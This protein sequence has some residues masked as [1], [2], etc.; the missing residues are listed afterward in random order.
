MQKTPG[1]TLL[2]LLITIGLIGLGIAAI[3]FFINIITPILLTIEDRPSVLPDL[4]Q[5]TIIVQGPGTI[6]IGDQIISGGT[7]SDIISIPS[8][9]SENLPISYN[10]GCPIAISRNGL[11]N[12]PITLSS[13]SDLISFTTALFEEHDIT[14]TELTIAPYDTINFLVGSYCW[15][16]IIMYNKSTGDITHGMIVPAPYGEDTEFRIPLPNGFAIDDSS[17]QVIYLTPQTYTGNP[18]ENFGGTTTE[19]VPSGGENLYCSVT[20]PNITEPGIILAPIALI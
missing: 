18:E 4:Q 20:I 3:P 15:H 10:G 16:A 13:Y 2:E 7:G 1:F 6:T 12:P 17:N 9:L 8:G 11:E 19:C 14:K 5:A